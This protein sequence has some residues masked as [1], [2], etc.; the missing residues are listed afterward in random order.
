MR[1]R[2]RGRKGKDAK[3][4]G[5]GK[6]KVREGGVPGSQSS[7]IG[8]LSAVLVVDILVG[9]WTFGSGSI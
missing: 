3:A 1:R 5:R 9:I 4:K 8:I 7:H 2:V 6:Q